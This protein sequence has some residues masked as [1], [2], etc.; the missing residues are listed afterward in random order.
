M[1]KLILEDVGGR[2]AEVKKTPAEAAAKTPDNFVGGKGS[3]YKIDTE[4]KVCNI[5]IYGIISTSQRLLNIISLLH[6]IPE[7]YTVFMHLRTPGGSVVTACNLLT[8]MERCKATI[9]T[10]NIGMAASCGSLILA[11]GDKIAIDP[12]SVTMFHN[13]IGGYHDTVHRVKTKIDHTIERI[14]DI[15]NKLVQKGILLESEINK[16]ISNGEEFFIPSDVII[17]RLKKCDMLYSGDLS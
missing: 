9:I 6:V 14:N 8:A 7:D 15:L 11:F 4:N 1:R 17:D 3:A 2:V 13:A 10:H 5:W 16:I 12:I